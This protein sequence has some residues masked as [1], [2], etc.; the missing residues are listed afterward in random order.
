MILWRWKIQMKTT[1]FRQLWFSSGDCKTYCGTHQE[2]CCFGEG[3]RTHVHI[4]GMNRISEC[5]WTLSN[6]KD[7]LSVDDGYLLGGRR[8]VIPGL[9]QSQLL[10]QLHEC[11]GMCRMKALVRSY[12]WWPGIDQDIEDKVRSC[13]VCTEVQ[14]TPKKV[15]LLL[16]PRATSLSEWIHLD[17]A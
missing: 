16:W 8:V 7:E 3:I 17:F 14:N 6:W 10:D 11:H 9:L 1:F 5:R 2:R 12:V 13:D 15:P 4:I